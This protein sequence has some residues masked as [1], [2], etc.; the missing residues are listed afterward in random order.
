MTRSALALLLVAA[1]ATA[2][3]QQQKF[4]FE[5][6]RQVTGVS[7]VQ[8]SPDGKTAIIDVT[9][10]NYAVDR[11]ESEL[12]AV[13]VA[14]GAVRQ[15]TAQR[16]VIAG[17]TFSP[18]GESVAFLSPDEGGEMQVWLMPM[19][20][21][22]ARRVTSHPTGVEHFAW[23]PDGKALAFAAADEPPKREGEDKFITAITLGDQDLFLRKTIEP[24]H[25]WLATLD[26]AAPKRLT[27]GKWTLEFALPPGSAPSAL[28]WA[29]DGGTIA[30]AHVVAPQSGRLDS[31][32]VRLLDVNTGVVRDLSSV[33]TFENNPVFSPDGRNVAFWQPRE[34]RADLNWV[35]EVW[36]AG[37]DGTNRRSVTRPLDRNLYSSQW[38]PDGKALLVAGND[39]DRVGAWIQPID[40]GAAK[41]LDVGDLVISGAYGYDLTAA[42]KGTIAFTATSWNHPAELY[43]M[44]TPDSKPRQLTHFNDW[45]NSVTFGRL[46]RVTWKSDKF[47]PD[48]VVAYPPDFSP[49]KSYPLVL[50]I[51]GGPTSA[52]KVNF[53]SLAQ[54]MAAEGWIVFQPNY[55]GSDNLGNTFQASILGDAGAGPGRDVMAGVAMLRARPFVDKSKTAVTGWS[56]GGYM[57]SWLIGN[58]PNEW[59]AAMAGAPVTNWEDMYNFADGSVA[60]RYSFG[61]S[62]W[63]DGREKAYREQSPITYARNIR[64]PTLV[65]TNMEDFRVPPTQAYAL[66]H[67]MKDNGVETEFIGFTGRTH[68]SSDPVNARERNRL[69]IDWV[70]KHL[71]PPAIVP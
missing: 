45:A 47:E 25:I 41:K 56:Y 44:D 43:V 61:G 34:G 37:A 3:A 65:M 51:H 49:Q 62:P 40:G 66:Y 60:L 39:H 12:Y 31:V 30:F 59:K 57:T 24:Q 4:T 36:V 53:S 69:W 32:H 55:R 70:R 18:N 11:N 27:S 19:H 52:S 22:E 26:G 29:A 2:G 50:L 9:R 35:N 20:G 21:G 38:M 48:G 46:E 64:T 58:Y 5:H 33:R 54:L 14:T 67:A 16:K 6:L 8:L 63:K 71:S 68:S 28:S 13:D 42:G 1:A 10:P 23:R 15:L 7:G 17:A